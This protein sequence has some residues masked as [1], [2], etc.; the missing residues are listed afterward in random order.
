MLEIK[1]TVDVSRNGILFRTREHYEMNSTIWVTMPF[2]PNVDPR[3]PEFPATVVRVIRMPD[4]DFEIGV[5]FHSAYADKWNNT[6][7]YSGESKPVTST[8][9]RTKNRVK[10]T[11]PIRVRCD[12]AKPAMQWSTATAPGADG[13]WIEES[14][15]LDMSRTGVLFVS[16]RP[17]KIGQ[18]VW[19]A[20]PYQPGG[21]L[22]EEPAEVIR[23]VDHSGHRGV[24]V[25]LT[26]RDAPRF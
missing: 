18:K 2:N 9:R 10:M 26:S 19:V 3:P 22:I 15:T 24:A 6:R 25:R 17:Y 16:R 7:L 13:L 5:Q 8:E 20:V 12:G 11:L 14:V 1:G 4:G 23:F 21:T